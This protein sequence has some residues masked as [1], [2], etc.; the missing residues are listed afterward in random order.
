MVNML[1]E[2]LFL[3]LSLSAMAVCPYMSF[4]AGMKKD[5]AARNYRYYSV[6][7]PRDKTSYQYLHV[8]EMKELWQKELKKQ[9]WISYAW[10]LGGAAG[11]VGYIYFLISGCV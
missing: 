3:L 11:L 7:K 8:S 1:F 9:T 5:K 6:R 2:F 10:M 4:V